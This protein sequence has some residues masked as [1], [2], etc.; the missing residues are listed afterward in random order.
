MTKT[1]NIIRKGCS[2]ALAILLM[3]S[4][5]PSL[6]PANAVGETISIGTPDDLKTFIKKCSM[7][8]YSKG[9][10][11]ELT[12]D[13]DM[14]GKSISPIPIFY[15]SFEGGGFTISN[16]T[17]KTKGSQIGFFRSIESEAIVSGLTISADLAP[18]GSA[19]CVGVIAGENR[20]TIFGCR[21]TG[22]VYG[23]N[24]VGG[25]VGINHPGGVIANCTNEAD[26]S[27]NYRT[28]GI[29]GSN[30]GIIEAAQNKG[31]VN[32]GPAHGVSPSGIS[33]SISTDEAVI[34]QIKGSASGS[35]SNTTNGEVDDSPLIISTGGITGLNDGAVRGCS[36]RGSVGYKHRGYNTGGIA[37]TH[38]GIINACEN[39][40]EILGHKDVG[41][42]VGQ[43]EP[44]MAISFGVS[45]GAELESQVFQL[46]ASL[47]NLTST[48]S[49]SSGGSPSG[50]GSINSA[51]GMIEDML[52]TH[53]STSG[54]KIEISLDALY[55]NLQII[56][57][58]ADRIS[59]Y[60]SDYNEIAA[61]EQ[62]TIVSEL[63]I[64]S[65]A[66]EEAKAAGES[67]DIIS[68]LDGINEQV[69]D[70]SNTLTS[71]GVL[72]TGITTV[73]QDD[74]LDNRAQIAAL[75]NDHYSTTNKNA[76]STAV[77]SISSSTTVI[78][79]NL[80]SINS[81]L[82]K[83]SP[84]IIQSMQII[85][86]AT[87]RLQKATASL[88]GGVS[89]QDGI[90]NANV[91]KIE[92]L[93]Y[94][95]SS[96]AGERLESSFSKVLIQ[97]NIINSGLEEII[98][99][100]DA[101]NVEVYNLLNSA[102]DQLDLIGATVSSLMDP[103]QYST[104]DVLGTIEQEEKPGQISSCHNKGNVLA[105]V[106]VGGIA[107]IMAL[108][109]DSDPEEDF[110]IRDSL[111]VN[112]AALFRAITMTSTN[113]APVIAKNECA[114]GS[115]GRCDLGLIYKCENLGVAETTEGNFCGGIVGWS[116]GSVIS[117]NCLC[118]LTGNDY[119]G[120]VAGLGKNLSNCRAMVRLYS[121]GECLGAIAGNAGGDILD[122]AFVDED[123]HGIDGISYA[124]LAYP[125]PYEEFIR[126]DF[127]SPIFT[128]LHANFYIDG[129]LIKQL[130][131]TY[132]GSIKSWD[133][134]S[135]PPKEDGFGV[136]EP[137]ESGK[138]LRSQTI[139]AVFSPWIST[140]SSSEAPALML[141][142]GKFSNKASI[143]I[144]DI[145]AKNKLGGNA[146]AA[147]SYS[148]S[149]PGGPKADE[150]MLHLRCEK[151]G[152]ISVE[153]TQRGKNVK[154]STKRDGIYLI[155]TG[156]GEGEL[157]IVHSQAKKIV[158]AVFIIL[159]VLVLLGFFIYLQKLFPPEE[160]NTKVVLPINENEIPK[161]TCKFKTKDTSKQKEKVR[162]PLRIKPV[163]KS[164]SQ[165]R[166]K[167]QPKQNKVMP[168]VGIA[169]EK[170]S[171][172]RTSDEDLTAIYRDTNWEKSE[173]S[174]SDVGGNL[175]IVIG[176]DGIDRKI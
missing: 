156:P 167:K 100:A 140:I 51:V 136:W 146:I 139:N 89:V 91:D 15:G 172:P 76:I 32:A 112:T 59:Q 124:G 132:G 152:D 122:N 14:G 31:S 126:L 120:G 64:I 66:L 117:C 43:F 2:L 174:S 118:D 141:A 150:Y 44:D 67:A 96:G 75:L 114:G 176:D 61:A 108:E 125:L 88:S 130:P 94:G 93:V 77:S 168:A 28:G 106:N 85:S 162:S 39:Y 62:P 16:Y 147:Y 142:E 74:D 68:R 173:L 40:G 157:T 170:P 17:V 104:I 171:T 13:I 92:D 84:V 26:V 33:D 123:L 69:A 3:I 78:V 151:P 19:S 165:A 169:A 1:R 41:G 60:L 160:K 99:T 8:S 138:T 5:A 42:I 119:V 47:H 23:K 63:E 54:E 110:A 115:V 10:S 154:L 166:A 105:D 133:I 127:L 101:T 79:E 158:M 35:N 34:N 95:S 135:I 6:S 50:A 71:I 87:S 109:M 52:K 9:L 45:N 98:T 37:G 149:D 21:V 128:D 72:I 4:L 11:A 80:K 56:N 153:L 30:F 86:T 163:F 73:L 145:T 97:L 113:I 82:S 20:G 27:G 137:F 134:P 12:A 29:T 83:G 81:K 107:G 90:T 102:L 159:A 57:T 103:P 121:D 164:F 49:K 65:V 143:E 36:N 111:W 144:E 55:G 129:K 116:N 7:D 155:F 38:S 131:L 48:L 24:D 46:T 58:A 148:I 18:K 53:S 175:D 25:L 70:I 22:T 161:K